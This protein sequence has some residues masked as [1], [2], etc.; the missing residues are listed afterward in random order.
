[1]P[2][3][4]RIGIDAHPIGD[5]VTGNERFLA[6][7]V[8]GLHE[9][10][11]EH[12]FVLY[13]TNREA[14][15]RW[16]RSP[17]TDIQVLRP[18][19][20]PLF[21]AVSLPAAARRDR[22]D[23]LI[24]Q[25]ATP[26]TVRCPVV[27]LVYDICFHVHPEFFTRKDRAWLNMM[28]RH[29]LRRAQH[30]VC[31]S[32]FSR[33]ELMERLGVRRDRIT[34]VYDGIGPPFTDPALRPSPIEPPFFLAVG[35]LAPRKNLATLVRGYRQALTRAPDLPEKLVIVGKGWIAAESIYEET[36]ELR[37]TGRVVFTGHIDDEQLVGLIQHATGLAYPSVYEGF[38]LPPME[39]MG[40]GTP[41]IVSDIPV[42]REVHDDASL[43]APPLDPAGWADALLRLATEGTFR[44]ELAR[45]G[46]ART[47]LFTWRAAGA[48][49]LEAVDV[50]MAG[51]GARRS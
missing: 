25:Y 34:V 39:A 48:K 3:R 43:F 9:A 36:A 51:S 38:G 29:S 15:E 22:L 31:S 8:E 16:P 42:M 4:L 1:M 23:A 5:R 49:T 17:R 6:G 28:V 47:E 50:A 7:L 37:R 14:A 18:G 11:D 32:K 21:F 44:D 40:A 2:A 41:A 26:P 27:A 30:I 33:A 20:T 35:S 13:F 12:E 24:T 19:S 46:K 45:R 10:S